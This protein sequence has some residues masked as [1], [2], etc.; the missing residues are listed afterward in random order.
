MPRF[1]PVEIGQADLRTR[2][3]DTVRSDATVVRF[4]MPVRDDD[5]PYLDRVEAWH[6]TIARIW[7]DTMAQHPGAQRVAL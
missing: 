7:T 4:D 1:D 5:L 6:D 2:I 3:I